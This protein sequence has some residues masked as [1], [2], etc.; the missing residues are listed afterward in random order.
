MT[1]LF[2]AWVWVSESRSCTNV[3]L[4]LSG[5]KR[6]RQGSAVCPCQAFRQRL[7]HWSRRQTAIPVVRFGDLHMYGTDVWIR[8]AFAGGFVSLVPYNVRR[9]SAFAAA[10]RKPLPDPV[11][12][13]HL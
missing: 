10:V 9:T 4:Y 3:S 1:V 11:L 5:A 6:A 2:L 8:A 7:A 12:A 13:I